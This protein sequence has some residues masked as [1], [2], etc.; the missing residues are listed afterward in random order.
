MKIKVIMELNWDSENQTVEDAKEILEE[1][2]GL[3]TTQKVL[4]I[5]E[6][7]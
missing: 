1:D 3:C 2:W 7:P 5:E 6:I 4:A